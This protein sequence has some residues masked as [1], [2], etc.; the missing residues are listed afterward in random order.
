MGAKRTLRRL[1][2]A[3]LLL[4]ACA[5]VS[6]GLSARAPELVGHLR[7]RA[8]RWLAAWTP[9]P[10]WRAQPLGPLL[11]QARQRGAL[12][13][14]VRAYPRPA[15]AGA[16]APPEP[17][18]Y[19]TALARHIADTLGVQARI[20]PL[21]SPDEKTSALDTLAGPQADL[22]LAGTRYGMPIDKGLAMSADRTVSAAYVTGRASLVALRAAAQAWRDL[23]A[24]PGAPGLLAGRSVCVQQGSPYAGR[25]AREHGAKPRPYPSSVHAAYAFMSGQCEVLAED[26]AVLQ[27]LMARQEWRFYQRLPIGI[28][29]DAR[30]PQILLARADATSAGYLDKVVRYWKASGALQQAREQR[31]GLVNL[32]VAALQDGLVCHS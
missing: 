12:V 27:R 9:A 2:A 18:D 30:Q 17:D 5:A 16:P 14:A 10:D 19:D 6:A 22:I 23:A 21:A 13:V 24:R 31:A 15:P 26:E 29:P 11:Q 4:A 20:V 8:Q 25:L 7:E 1:G 32:E 28:E 3:T